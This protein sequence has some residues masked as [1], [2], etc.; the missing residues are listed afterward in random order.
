MVSDDKSWLGSQDFEVGPSRLKGG[1]EMN[2][3]LAHSLCTLCWTHQVG[4]LPCPGSNTM[5]DSPNEA[6][7]PWPEHPSHWTHQGDLHIVV[8]LQVLHLTGA[9]RH[10]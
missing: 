7:P 8:G 5:V 10:T 3:S 1:H 6:A 2:P 9:A 4:L